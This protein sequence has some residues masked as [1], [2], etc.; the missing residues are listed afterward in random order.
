MSNQEREYHGAVL[1]HGKAPY[2]HDP[3]Q[4]DSYFVTL[5]TPTGEK[6]VWGVDLERAMEE[7]NKSVGDLIRLE[8]LGSQPVT[9]Q[10]EDRDA[11]GNLLGLK[12]KTFNRNTWAACDWVG[13]GQLAANEGHQSDASGWRHPA[14]THMNLSFMQ[15]VM[16]GFSGL[17]QLGRAMAVGGT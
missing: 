9:L 6:T 2:N 16:L 1:M 17:G 5:S 4:K 10:V 13:P 7:G 12:E 8:F 11:N 15:S 14:P 3:Q